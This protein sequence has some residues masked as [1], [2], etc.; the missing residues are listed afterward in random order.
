MD[1]FI[2][3]YLK[4]AEFALA[5][6]DVVV[7]QHPQKGDLVLNSQQTGYVLLILPITPCPL[8]RVLHVPSFE[9]NHV[10]LGRLASPNEKHLLNR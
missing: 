8:L 9:P 6:A 5:L 7:E 3:R 4:E 10:F 1:A 2:V